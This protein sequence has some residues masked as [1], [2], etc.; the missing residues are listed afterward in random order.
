M[1]FYKHAVIFA[2]GKSSRMGKDKSLLPF[3][4]ETTLAQYQYEKLKKVFHSVYF[5]AKNKKFDFN[6]QVILDNYPESSPLVAILSTFE[7]LDLDAIF[8]LSVDAPF[9]D[10]KVIQEI[11]ENDAENIDVIVAKSPSGLQPLCGLY[12]KSVLP[13]ARQQYEKGNHKIK[14]LL[15]SVRTKTVEFKEDNPFANLNHPEEYK[16]AFN[17]SLKPFC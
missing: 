17:L 14:D 10:E 7:T 1:N 16:K 8:I 2:G 15:N 6:A 3:G 9:V 13:S 11:I 4:E 12:K 5:S